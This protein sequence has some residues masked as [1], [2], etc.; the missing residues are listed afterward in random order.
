M[1]RAIPAKTGYI[2]SNCKIEKS[3]VK[4]VE[5]ILFRQKGK[6]KKCSFYTM[7]K[8]SKEFIVH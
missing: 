6:T 5:K 4:K 1:P 3:I 7:K 2:S 8:W